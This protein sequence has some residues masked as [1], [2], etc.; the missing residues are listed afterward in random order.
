MII[1]RSLAVAVL[2]ALS[3][4][5]LVSGG[6]QEAPEATKAEKSNLLQE[7][8]RSMSAEGITFDYI[9]LNKETID[10]LFPEVQRP[11]MRAR[12][13]AGTMFFIQ[14][15][16][17][18]NILQFDPRFTIRQGGESYEGTVIN[19]M[20]LKAGVLERGARLQGLLQLG[21]KIDVTQ[22]F[23]ISFSTATTEFRLS[24]NAIR[25]LAN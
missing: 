25:I 5:L 2:F 11:A 16:P 18:R 9:L 8:T 19:I 13:N 22:S 14:G 12:A 20:N 24:D 10:I 21:S 7:F 15:V 3:G 6:A 23:T 17:T 1:K 4:A